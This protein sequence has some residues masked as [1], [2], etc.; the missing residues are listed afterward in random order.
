LL[1]IGAVPTAGTPDELGG[2]FRNEVARFAK[3][4]QSI[5][6]KLD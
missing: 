1:G 2:F 4:V 3:V 5:G 6:L